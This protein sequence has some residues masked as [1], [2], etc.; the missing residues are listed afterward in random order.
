MRMDEQRKDESCDCINSLVLSGAFK[1]GIGLVVPFLDM[2]L[3]AHPHEF[4]FLTAS[5]RLI[6]DP[7]VSTAEYTTYPTPALG[8]RVVPRRA[9]RPSVTP[10]GIGYEGCDLR[11]VFHGLF[12]LV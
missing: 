12:P 11:F 5:N 10:R 9:K 8:G 3:A 4:L 1:S 6:K 2:S 7:S